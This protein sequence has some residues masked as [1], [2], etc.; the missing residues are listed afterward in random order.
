MM[1]L[2]GTNT[3]VMVGL[4]RGVVIDPGPADA[5]HIAVVRRHAPV[6]T[7]MLSHR[8]D[9]HSAAIEG[10]PAQTPVYALDPDLARGVD[11]LTDG[12]RLRIDG[13]EFEVLHTPG[14]TDDS[15]CFV[16]DS[17]TGPTVFTG[18]TLLGGRHATYISRFGG[19]LAQYLGS[20]K[21]LSTFTGYRGLPG[22]GPVIADVGSHAQAALDYRLRRVELLV[23]QLERGGDPDPSALARARYPE[24]PDRWQAAARMFEAELVYLGWDSGDFKNPLR[25]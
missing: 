11:V 9:D 3:W 24:R 23:A 10:F 6:A 4:M 19:V 1:T 7:I 20:L 21:R 8:H 25:R 5:S 13:L 18:D 14:H 2:T 16:A 17:V 12:Q 15:V 22:H